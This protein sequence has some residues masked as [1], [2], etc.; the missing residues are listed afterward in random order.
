MNS[1][2]SGRQPQHHDTQKPTAP[3]SLPAADFTIDETEFDSTSSATGGTAMT[4]PKQRIH[5]RFWTWVGSFDRGREAFY[6]VL[7]LVIVAAGVCSYWLLN[8]S[9][10]P[11]VAAYP[12][13]RAPTAKTV[14]ST[15]TG[16]QVDPAVNKLQVT[17]VMIENSTFAR[18]Q[19]GLAQAGIVYEAIAEGGITRFMALFQDTKADYIG[20]VRSARPYYLTW[21]QSFDCA[22]A[23]VGGSPEALQD[24]KDWGVKNLD[25]FAGGQYF[26][27]VSSRPAP[28]NM[29][30]SQDQ[31]TAYE[32]S[33][34]Y[35]VSSYTGFS[36][37]AKEPK[38][39]QAD[40]KVSAVDF[41]FPGTAYDVHY[42]Y[43][44]ATN[45]YLRSEGGAPHY[46]IDSAGKQVRNAPKVVIGLV[47]PYSIQS[48]GDHSNYA[49][50]GSGKLY[51]F[52]NGAVQ[53]GTWSKAS[54]T[55]QFVFKDDQGNI[56]RL[57]PGQAWLT[58]VGS[59]GDVT[60]K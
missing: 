10:T 7:A 51:V 21:C 13:Y 34:G 39:V 50:I 35:T 5:R 55:D 28:H 8:H 24:I 44:L 15:L 46:S 2:G 32:Q 23:H 17:G 16:L 60:Y 33:R 48:D 47:I 36:H 58:A 42:D 25:Q 30:T 37:L 49:T 43:D 27:R 1:E 56:L 52:Q 12:T 9:S 31:L 54:R 29:Y 18:P 41:N 40:V 22:I 14:Q 3:S 57:D 11:P 4:P 19:S 20:P 26:H 59:T 45:T 6:G 38:V 53:T